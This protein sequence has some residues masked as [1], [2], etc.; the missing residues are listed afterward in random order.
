MRRESAPDSLPPW[1]QQP[2]ERCPDRRQSTRSPSRRTARE[3]TGPSRWRS[4]ASCGERIRSRPA[5]A[6]SR[7]EFRKQPTSNSC[8]IGQTCWWVRGT[9]TDR[10]WQSWRRVAQSR[11]SKLCGWNL[12]VSTRQWTR[13]LWHRHLR[14]QCRAAGTAFGEGTL[15]CRVAESPVE[16]RAVDNWAESLGCRALPVAESF[17][18]AADTETARRIAADS[19]L[20]VKIKNELRMSKQ[21]ISTWNYHGM[22][23]SQMIAIVCLNEKYFFVRH[24][25]VAK[26]IASWECFEIVN[27]QLTRWIL[28]LT[29]P[30]HFFQTFNVTDAV[31]TKLSVWAAEKLNRVELKEQSRTSGWIIFLVSRQQSSDTIWWINSFYHLCLPTTST[32]VRVFHLLQKLC[33]ATNFHFHNRCSKLQRRSCDDFDAPKASTHSEKSF[34]REWIVGKSII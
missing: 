2:S 25:C 18:S 33:K 4:S 21:S 32:I 8:A 7:S 12:C 1:S 9:R 5:Q 14:D 28:R 10:W 15:G 23:N 16:L 11:S 30:S 13:N 27:L 6:S 31:V 24:K 17:G 26:K 20:D 29:L 3:W 19:D 34:D 22:K